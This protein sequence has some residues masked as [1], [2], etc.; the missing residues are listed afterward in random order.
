MNGMWFKCVGG[1]LYPLASRGDLSN[2]EISVTNGKLIEVEAELFT[3]LSNEIIIINNNRDVR[4]MSTKGGS[5]GIVGHSSAQRIGK[6]AN[7]LP[8]STRY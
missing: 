5:H 2:R 6:V 4:S 8:D 7:E 1:A 3:M